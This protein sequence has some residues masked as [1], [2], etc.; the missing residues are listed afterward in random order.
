MLRFSAEKG[1]TTGWVN[2]GIDGGRDFGRMQ[3]ASAASRAPNLE[4]VE[5][6]GKRFMK[7][8]L[9]DKVSRLEYSIRGD[10][11]I[12]KGGTVSDWAGYDVDLRQATSFKL[13]TRVDDLQREVKE[14]RATVE[15][16]CGRKLSEPELKY[17]RGNSPGK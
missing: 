15:D 7:I 8:T 13:G 16:F 12:V 1:K 3:V 10:E 6:D 9:R 2:M 14:L 11:L 5:K 4:L 17:L